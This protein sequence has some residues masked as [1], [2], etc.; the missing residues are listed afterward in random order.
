MWDKMA[1]SLEEELTEEQHLEKKATPVVSFPHRFG[2]VQ[3]M[4]LLFCFGAA[5]FAFWAFQAALIPTL[6]HKNVSIESNY[7][8]FLFMGAVVLCAFALFK[9]FNLTSR[10]AKVLIASMLIMCIGTRRRSDLSALDVSMS[11]CLDVSN[12][13]NPVSLA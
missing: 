10:G 13:L 11:Q 7:L 2:S 9:F 3:G 4:L 5:V 12:V 6:Q 1:R 8:L